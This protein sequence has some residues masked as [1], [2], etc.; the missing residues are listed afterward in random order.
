MLRAFLWPTLLGPTPTTGRPMVVSCHKALPD[1]DDN[2][3]SDD[4]LS[5]GGMSAMLREMLSCY[6]TTE[7]TGAVRLGLLGTRLDALSINRVR[8][9]PSTIAG[10]GLGV[11]AT[12]TLEAGEMITLY[13]GD[14]LLHFA[15]GTVDAE[16][17][18]SADEVAV[19]FASHVPSERRQSQTRS[20][21]ALTAARAYELP[22]T[23]MMS[24]VGD[25]TLVDDPAYL[26]HMLNDVMACQ[27]LSDLSSYAIATASH[28]NAAHKPLLGC[29]FASVT[30]RRVEAG[31]ELFASYGPA[32]WLSRQGISGDTIREAEEALALEI[33]SGGAL[34]D[35]LQAALEPQSR[36][37]SS[38]AVGKE[39]ASSGS[40]S[41]RGQK[42][43]R[44]K[45]R[46]ADETRGAM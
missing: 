6:T 39:G 41:G 24:L 32:Y 22:A 9:A 10:G 43:G 5:L 15:D 1:P 25:P 13:P 42:I 45:R 40:S 7:E 28:V 17:D 8:I 11:F 34:C 27:S 2:V 29:H 35:A 14:A 46:R 4:Q 18:V 33:R 38:M 12:R 44:Q 30:T 19:S 31:S 23:S 37:G 36:D 16:G 20:A 21:A 3:D 26:G